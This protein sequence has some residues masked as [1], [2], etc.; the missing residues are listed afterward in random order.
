[1]DAAETGLGG[2][3]VDRLGPRLLVLPAAVDQRQVRH[4]AGAFAIVVEE[5]PQHVSRTALD[6]LTRVVA[7]VGQ[8]R[9]LW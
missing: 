9:G 8:F 3:D 6:V 4:P 5:H 1:M 7:H 2:E